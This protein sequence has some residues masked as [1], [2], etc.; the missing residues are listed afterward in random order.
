MYEFNLMNS[1][2]TRHVKQKVNSTFT[3]YMRIKMAIKMECYAQ[4]RIPGT[5]HGWEIGALR[6]C[7]DF[8]PLL[9]YRFKTNG[10]LGHD[11]ALYGYTGPGK[12]WDNEKML[13]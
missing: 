1:V 5:I 11:S 3:A 9:F 10:V 6:I 12:T 8:I 2:F 4:W 13:S 7:H